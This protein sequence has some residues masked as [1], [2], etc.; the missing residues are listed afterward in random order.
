[1]PAECVHLNRDI[2]EPV[3]PPSA[4]QAPQLQLPRAPPLLAQGAHGAG[5]HDAHGAAQLS[6]AGGD[7][8]LPADVPPLDRRLPR[9]PQLVAMFEEGG[10][11][12]AGDFYSPIRLWSADL[13][14][15]ARH[16]SSAFVVRMSQYYGAR[17]EHPK[18][19]WGDDL[20]KCKMTGVQLRDLG[21]ALKGAKHPGTSWFDLVSSLAN[22]KAAASKE[23][24]ASS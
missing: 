5:A 17:S 16:D 2:P 18:N 22:S 20:L 7:V 9:A 1:V 8:V 14:A 3:A 13:R 24:A 19:T 6:G 21:T 15:A 10:T 4:L 11:D 23:A 12:D